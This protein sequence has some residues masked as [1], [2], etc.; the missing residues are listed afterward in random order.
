MAISAR[1]T[2]GTDRSNAMVAQQ[3]A[4]GKAVCF[5]GCILYTAYFLKLSFKLTLRLK[6]RCSGVES[7]LSRQ[8]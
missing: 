4:A 3:D 1:S 7:L 5:T 2:G 8:K 6:T